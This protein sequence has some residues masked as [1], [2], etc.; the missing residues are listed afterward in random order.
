M[1][2]ADLGQSLIEAAAAAAAAA[3]S[4]AGAAAAAQQQPWVPSAAAA[5]PR[6]SGGTASRPQSGGGAA[7]AA[8]AGAGGLGPLSRLAGGPEQL[9]SPGVSPA[10]VRPRRGRQMAGSP[11][12]LKLGEWLVSVILHLGVEQPDAS[13][14][15]GLYTLP[16]YQTHSPQTTQNNPAAGR[17]GLSASQHPSNSAPTSPRAADSPPRPGSGGPAPP[18]AAAAAKGGA[19]GGRL[20]RPLGASSGG[21][22]GPGQLSASLDSAAFKKALRDAPAGGAD[23]T[24]AGMMISAQKAGGHPMSGSGARLSNGGDG[25]VGVAPLAMGFHEGGGGRE[26]GVGLQCCRPLS[27]VGLGWRPRLK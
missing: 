26:R 1:G 16:C 13:M 3:P 14:F 7:G 17:R 10:R 6:V 24:P 18:G 11:P 27:R 4:A 20:A 8:A 19:R 9:G 22:A 2:D 5:A 23:R 12:D 25:A 21:N 15:C